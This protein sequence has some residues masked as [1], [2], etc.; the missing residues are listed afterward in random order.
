M[1]IFYAVLSGLMILIQGP[2]LRKA[3]QLFSEEKLVIIG[4]II[5][6][7]N[8][9]LFVANNTVLVFQLQYFLHLVMDLCGHLSCLF[10]RCVQELS[11]KEPFKGLQVV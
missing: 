7:I 1:G 4:S 3:L 11:I 10:F 5:L 9:I 6:G 8:F 2:I